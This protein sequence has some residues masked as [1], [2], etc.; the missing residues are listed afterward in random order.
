VGA[1]QLPRPPSQAICCSEDI[2][3]W[4]R[5]LCLSSDCR[6]LAG[7]EALRCP[8]LLNG[9]MV[10]A[11]DGADT[12]QARANLLRRLLAALFPPETVEISEGNANLATLELLG[13]TTRTARKKRP[14]RRR[15]AAE[16]YVMGLNTFQR[17]YEQRL[18]RDAAEALWG[19]E[20]QARCGQPPTDPTGVR[21]APSRY[22]IEA[23]SMSSPPIPSAQHGRGAGDGP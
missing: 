4:F 2:Y 7:F 17:N 11:P 15:L 18:I 22:P 16:S 1:R 6:G 19:L 13:L 5:Y 20:L 23:D 12:L 10:L 14:L 3:S 21:L 9:L 8:E